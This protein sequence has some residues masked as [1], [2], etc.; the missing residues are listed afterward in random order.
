MENRQ[1]PPACSDATLLTRDDLYLF[2]EGSHF[3]LFDKLGAHQ[4]TVNGATGTYFAVWAPNAERVSV[5]GTFNDWEPDRHPLRMRDS[6]GIWEA[7]LPG[8][9]KGALYKYQVHSRFLGYCVDKSD[10]FSFFNEIPPR[11]ASIVWDLGYRWGDEAWMRERAP[12]NSLDAP[13]SI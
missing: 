5:I 2:N 1:Q 8:V 11:T 6:S 13:I 3:R 10:P 12:R 4:L 9:G 7:F